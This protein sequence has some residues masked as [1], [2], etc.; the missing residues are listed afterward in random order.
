[1]SVEQILAPI[2]MLAFGAFYFF[3]KKTDRKKALLCKALATAI[4][5]CMMLGAAGAIPGV[6]ADTAAFAGTLLAI[7]FYMTADVLLECRFIWGAI[8]FGVGHICMSAGFLA[9]GGGALYRGEAGGALADGGL[10]RLT[11][12]VF[13]VFVAAACGA[14][15]RFFHSLR[16]KK[17]LYPMLAYVLLLSAMAALAV[18][19]G[20][21]TVQAGKIQGLIPIAGGVCFGIS[22]ILL[23]RNRLGKR[24]SVVCS[25]LV[26]ILYY[27]AVYLLA[28]RLWVR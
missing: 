27:L 20:F 10:L 28:M 18:T 6:K 26:L 1:M 24:R 9:G 5:G 23:G 16:K 11:A 14:L 7:V 22:D 25:A 19:E 21:R 17:L 12:V 4:P 13:A 3:K 15:H 8:C 2:L